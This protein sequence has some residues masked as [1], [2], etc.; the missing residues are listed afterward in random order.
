MKHSKILLS[1]ALVGIMFPLGCMQSP[2]PKPAPAPVSSAAVKS[3]SEVKLE[4]IAYKANRGDKKAQ[5]Q[6][7]A[8]YASGNG[9]VKDDVLSEQW[10]LRADPK[11]SPTSGGNANASIQKKNAEKAAAEKE[12][13]AKAKTSAQASAKNAGGGNTAK[14]APKKT[15]GTS[16]EDTS[17]FHLGEKSEAQAAPASAAKTAPAASPKPK[18]RDDFQLILRRASQ[19]DRAALNRIRNDAETRRKFAAYAKTP[20]GKRNPFVRE[21]LNRLKQ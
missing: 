7:A 11:K 10:L 13:A 2:K 17:K 4:N 15:T 18:A 21:V 16:P 14:T 6:L 9:V 12:A 8:R 19:G 5:E 3:A 1:L 20:E